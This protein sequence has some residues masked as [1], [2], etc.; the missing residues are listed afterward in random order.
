DE[1]FDLAG[2]IELQPKYGRLGDDARVAGGLG[3]GNLR[4][5]DASPGAGRAG[6][7]G[8]AGPALRAPVV[9]K[10]V[11]RLGQVMEADSERP[12][13]AGEQAVGVTEGEGWQ[14]ERCAAR[15][16]PWLVGGAGHAEHA[17]GG[18]VVW[19]QVLIRDRP[20][21]RDPVR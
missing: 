3:L 1:G 10:R 12:A 8:A 11:T 18:G 2:R 20:V 16:G 17:L 6:L 19:L 9:G 21:L 5:V 14:G 15:R 7:A 4:E 13:R